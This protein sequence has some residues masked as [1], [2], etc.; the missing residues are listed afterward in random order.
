MPSDLW[1]E[2]LPLEK[3]EAV[4]KALNIPQNLLAAIVQ[5]ESS[6]NP[7]SVRFEPAYSYFWDAKAYAK[8]LNCSLETEMNMQACSYGLTQ[9]MGAVC[10]EYGFA[11]WFGGL[12]NVELNL[13]YGGRHI[14]K[15]LTKYPA[16]ITDAISSYNQGSPR[17][18][19]KGK[20][21][22]QEYVDAVLL[23]KSILDKKNSTSKSAVS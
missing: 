3:I 20:Y 1:I 18:D 21:L 11:G 5:K 22:N 15:F 2:K 6:G 4:S 14:K 17:K 8:K 10:R 16:G 13:M 23:N 19:A 7:M 9:V 12:Y